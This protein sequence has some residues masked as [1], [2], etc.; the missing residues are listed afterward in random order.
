MK[1][2]VE[3]EVYD[4]ESWWV[5]R[6]MGRRTTKSIIKEILSV[7]EK[8]AWQTGG[9]TI[10]INPMLS[11]TNPLVAVKEKLRHRFYAKE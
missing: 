5:T 4:F 7:G 1:E 10:G 6:I 8:V 11:A 2:G 9:L 3:C